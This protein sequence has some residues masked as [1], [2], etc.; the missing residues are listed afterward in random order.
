MAG[1]IINFLLLQDYYN[2]LNRDPFGV[3][4]GNWGHKQQSRFGII[5][6]SNGETNVKQ[7]GLYILSK[8]EY[9]PIISQLPFFL[10][11]CIR[12]HTKMLDLW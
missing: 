8:K 10:S 12:N 5:S 3:M 2:K 6:K 9:M 4:G 7:I 1:S 11:K